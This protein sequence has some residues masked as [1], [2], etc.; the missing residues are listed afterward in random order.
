[1]IINLKKKHNMNLML[2]FYF[3]IKNLAQITHFSVILGF[4]FTYLLYYYSFFDSFY[5]VKVGLD[6]ASCALQA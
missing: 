2:L 6:L 5:V 4:F 1:M 3:I